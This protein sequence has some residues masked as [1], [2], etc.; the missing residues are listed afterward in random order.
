MQTDDLRLTSKRNSDARPFSGAKRLWYCVTHAFRCWIA[1]GLGTL[2]WVGLQAQ[3]YDTANS[4]Q[5]EL[6]R[7]PGRMVFV[8]AGDHVISQ[9]IKLTSAGSGL[10]GPGRIIQSNPMAAIVEVDGAADVQVRDV[11]LT[12][13]EGK[14]ETY[15]AGLRMAGCVNLTVANVRVVNNWSDASSIL[16]QNSSRVQVRDCLVRN[17]ARISVDDRTK[18]SFLGY[19]FNCING[20]GIN[21]MNVVGAQVV[22]NRIIEQ[23]LLPTPELKAKYSLGKIVRKNAQK[24]ALLSQESWDSNY[25]NLWRQGAA[26]HVG[27]G[28]TSAYFQLIGNSIENAQQ[29]MDIHADHVVVANNIVTDAAH[30]VK[31]MHG[32]RNILIVG[33]QFSKNDLFGI[34]L[35]QGTSSHV[36]GERGN[37]RGPAPVAA[38]VDGYSIIAHN[39]ISDF[40]F[41]MSRWIWPVS[42]TTS[43]DSVERGIYREV[44][45]LTDRKGHSTGPAPIGLGS[46]ALANTPPLRDVISTGT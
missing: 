5:E 35:M 31:A 45:S 41:G 43:P 23:R 12:R 6:D 39:I 13:S 32:A 19:A 18:T 16:I 22:N 40:G 24:G 30:G 10:W 2:G 1:A 27:N 46:R 38:N 37:D 34:G 4:I 26:L 29:G 25:V 21:F 15:Q 3:S 20:T 7:N 17:Y 36:A 42:Q 14:M 28:E 44:M 8:P 9:A 11:T 33:N